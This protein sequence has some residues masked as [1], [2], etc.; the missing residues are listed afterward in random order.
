L[1][2]LLPSKV[3]VRRAGSI[4]VVDASEIVPGDVLLLDVG[5]ERHVVGANGADLKALARR[6]P[7]FFETALF[8]EA[9]TPDQIGHAHEFLGDPMEVALIEMA[10]QALGEMPDGRRLDE[11]PFDPDRKRLSTVFR[12]RDQ[13]LVYTKGALES[14]VPLC[15]RELTFDGLRPLDESRRSELL[16]V[17]EELASQGL[18]VLALACREVS[19]DYDRAHLEEE[20][21][22][23]GLVGLE[24]PPR[25][26]VAEAISDCQRAGIAV[27]MVTGDHPTTATAIACR[28]GLIRGDHPHVITGA[29]LRAM[30]DTEL[31]LALD[32]EDVHFARLDPGQKVRIVSALQQKGH[33]VA[34]TG[35][36]VND[37]PA[38]KKGDI[39]VAMG[40][41][42]TDAA[43]EAADM[44]LA[45]D[46][47][48]T[49]V[50]AVAEGRAV[51]A[52]IRKFLTY[53]FS[54]NVAEMMPFVVFVL[55]K[56]PLPL[57]VLLVL[58]IDLGTDMIPALGLGAEEPDPRVMDRPPHRP[59]EHLLDKTVIARAFGFLGP[60]EGLAGLAA[61]IGVLLQSGWS[62]GESLGRQDPV[63]LQATTAC[64]AAIVVMQVINLMHCRDDTSTSLRYGFSGNRVLWVGLAFE[65]ALL[66]GLTYVPFLRDLFST[67]P[68]E[69]HHW[70]WF[71]P[72]AGLFWALEEVRK[73]V[74]RRRRQIRRAA[75]TPAGR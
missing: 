48:A 29:K 51:F 27:I 30:R 26:E 24:D 18:R 52:N 44:V 63:Y 64:F 71:V 6:M 5:G 72:M 46:N 39:G 69:A 70:L 53:I 49:I 59:G 66:F 32:H 58:A 15:C 33:V 19:P 22:L 68:L 36:G 1:E 4:A 75:R 57:P 34:V 47:F 35:D 17:Q 37:A 62:Y 21:T 42:G 54:S 2:R 25:E 10:Q 40:K 13:T 60:M 56:V 3:S 14:L 16:A 20:L 7:T 55:L 65:V 11:L 61:Y 45:D 74:V 31:M 43:R 38:L 41:G 23:L 8:S 28:L 50:A 67:A 12:R 73:F 9:T